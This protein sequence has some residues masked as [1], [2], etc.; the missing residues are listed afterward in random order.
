[1]FA[2]AELCSVKKSLDNIVGQKIQLTSKRGRKKSVIREGVVEG[3]Y[4]SVFV[5]K[6]SPTSA[7]DGRRISFSYTD[8][9]T[10]A[11]EV[12]VYKE[13]L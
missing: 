7:G 13:A 5:I 11:I 8:V 1:M 2:K 10:K 6:L 9:L 4:P 12:A 3:T